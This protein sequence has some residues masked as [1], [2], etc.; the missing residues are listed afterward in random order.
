VKTLNN[1]IKIIVSGLDFAGKT[2]ILTALDKKY[3]FQK[4]IMELK[5][6]IK[7]EYHQTV[8]LGNLCY[9]WD[10]GG[11]EKY[12]DLYKKRQDVY[13]AGTDLLVYVIDIQDKDRFEKSL[14]YLDVILQYFLDNK[15][16]TP[17]IVSFHKYDPELRGIEE[18]NNN[19]GELREIIIEKYP[20]FKILFQQTSIY[21]IISIVQLI[22]YGLSIFDEKFFELSLLLEDYLIN[23]FNCN[24]LILFDINGIIISEFYK[25]SINSEIYIELL[26]TI[27]EHLFL[28]KRMQEEDYK[29]DYN[30]F[31]FGNKLISYL[32]KIKFQQESY[33]ISV[34][35]DE[36]LKENLLEKFPDFIEDVTKILINLFS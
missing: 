18:I 10:M 27:K 22:S 13:F 26:D 14:A 3:N 6:T 19:I 34:I 17:I 5:P 15:M 25:D 24:S 32:H 31:S 36:N 7:V 28:L 20:T 9:F 21:D 30:I 12:L 11:Q 16:D 2:S 4:E 35:I 33:Y 23:K 8:F 1:A 29:L